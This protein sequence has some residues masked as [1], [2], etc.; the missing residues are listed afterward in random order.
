MKRSFKGRRASRRQQ[1]GFTIIE[2]MVTLLIAAVL[3]VSAIR[4]YIEYAESILDNAVIGHANRMMD[5]GLNYIADN[6]AAIEAGTVSSTIVYG[7]LVSGGYIDP[8]VSMR[9][10]YG[11]MAVV[12]VCMPP[13]Y[14]KLEA[15]LYYRN[16]NNISGKSLRS[17]ANAVGIAGG[18]VDDASG[19]AKGA[20]GGWT[21]TL[22]D[23]NASAVVPGAGHNVFYMSLRETAQQVASGNYVHRTSVSGRPELNRMGVNLDMG[24]NELRNASRVYSTGRISA[25]EYI[26]LQAFATAGAACSPNGLLARNSAGNL[27][28]CVSGVWR[29]AGT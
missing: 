18:Y 4:A 21:K 9:N 20:Y 27:L 7:S 11:Q 24:G 14:T 25:G 23:C 5:A 8:S 22:S 28:S 13:G 29:L 26:E 15:I 12:Q 3:T 10:A 19:I 17:I 16:G 2:M 6:K 1:E